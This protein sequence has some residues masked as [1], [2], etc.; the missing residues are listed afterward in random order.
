MSQVFLALLSLAALCGY[1]NFVRVS[2]RL[3]PLAIPY[4]VFCGLT[5]F[6]YACGLAGSHYLRSGVYWAVALGLLAGYRSWRRP[7]KEGQES[8][9]AVEALA[10]AGLLGLA[11]AI[12]AVMPHDY[13]FVGWDEFSHWALSAKV[14]YA[15]DQLVTRDSVIAFKAYPPGGSVFQYIWTRCFGFSEGNVLFAQVLFNWSAVLAAMA[16]LAGRDYVLAVIGGIAGLILMS[17]FGLKVASLDAD[18][19][20]A[21]SFAATMAYALRPRMSPG[22]IAGFCV[23]LA[24]FVLAKSVCLP[25]AMIVV[26]TFFGGVLADEYKARGGELGVRAFM[27]PLCLGGAAL[28]AVVLA[29]QS[30]AWH[31]HAIGGESPL[32]IPNPEQVLAGPMVHRIGST[33]AH[34]LSTLGGANAIQD[35]LFLPLDTLTALEATVRLVALGFV[36]WLLLSRRAGIRTGVAV[37][38]LA[39]GCLAYLGLL[40]FLYVVWFAEGEGNVAAGFARYYATYLIAWSMVLVAL[41]LSWMAGLRPRYRYV[42]AAMLLGAAVAATPKNLQ[43]EQLF[44]AD[45]AQ[46]RAVRDKLEKEAAIARTLI[47]GGERVFFVEQGSTGYE[48]YMFNYLMAPATSQWGCWSLGPKLDANDVWSC[49]L[50]ME[51][52]AR[53]ARV[54]VLDKADARFW[55][56]YGRYFEPADVGS[57]SGIFRILRVGKDIRLQRV[58]P[59]V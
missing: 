24:A 46:R 28:L 21:C 11:L 16:L 50:P 4:V 26:A 29:Q 43:P 49:E 13:R 44:G 2:T 27:R 34:V 3:P 32:S 7:P 53:Y 10:V 59:G 36:A 18:T 25:F 19:L 45:Y 22:E 14:M 51:N 48:S 5:V 41:L 15:E 38:A 54:L 57:A 6:V 35:G 56:A 52:I 30:W 9:G 20:V 40:M 17:L 23:C 42:L 1:F 12:F 37:I 47:L 33:V 39:G 55:N 8:F 31:V 58:A